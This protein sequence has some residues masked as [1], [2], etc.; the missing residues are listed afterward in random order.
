MGNFSGKFKF[1]QKVVTF[2]LN[3]NRTSK[4][5]DS[6]EALIQCES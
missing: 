1:Y 2:D 4:L 3:T 6:G 5:G